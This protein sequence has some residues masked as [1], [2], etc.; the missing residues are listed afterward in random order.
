MDTE[1]H[2]IKSRHNYDN[3]IFTTNSKFIYTIERINGEDTINSYIVNYLENIKVIDRV[4]LTVLP[5]RFFGQTKMKWEYLSPNDSVVL[6]TI[7]G[8]VEDATTVWVHPPRNGI[9]LIYTESAPF[10]EVR[11]PLTDN[12]SWTLWTENF[13]GTEQ[14]GL[15]GRIDFKYVNLGKASIKTT[16]KLYSDCWKFESTGESIIG[17][18]KHI[19]YFDRN[20]GFVYSMY[21]FPNGEKL[22]LQLKE[23]VRP[24]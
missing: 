24:I 16:N 6:K 13:K 23:R 1:G 20:D 4:T 3:S 11:F 2:K 7:S 9:P 14:I 12:N 5:G 8:L 10:P 19:F 21:D 15:E 22:I 18:S 17:F